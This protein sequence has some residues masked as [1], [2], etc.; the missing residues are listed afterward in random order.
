M[1]VPYNRLSEID[2]RANKNLEKLDVTYNE[3]GMNIYLLESHKAWPFELKKT[4]T[5]TSSTNKTHPRTGEAAER[6][7]RRFAYTG[8]SGYPTCSSARAN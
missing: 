5:P 1:E 4:A 8:T 6:S 2:A 7:L 3:A